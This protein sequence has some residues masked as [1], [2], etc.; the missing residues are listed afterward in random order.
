MSAVNVDVGVFVFDKINCFLRLGDRGRGF[1]GALEHNR[2]PVGDAAVDTA[3]VVCFG[4][5][6]FAVRAQ[7]IVTSTASVVGNIEA[8]AELDA[9]NAAETE[10]CLSLIHI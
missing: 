8:H 5:D 7:R 3:V 9:F 4:I 10:Q 1:D 2:H 6:L